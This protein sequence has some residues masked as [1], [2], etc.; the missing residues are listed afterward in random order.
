MNIWDIYVRNIDVQLWVD[1]CESS[2]L[3]LA[4]F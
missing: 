1:V 2:D 4:V 3:G